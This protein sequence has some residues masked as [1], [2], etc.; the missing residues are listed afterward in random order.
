MTFRAS[1]LGVFV[2]AV[3]VLSACSAGDGSFAVE[4]G[5]DVAQASSAATGAYAVAFYA[6]VLPSGEQTEEDAVGVQ[7]FSDG[8][9]RAFFCGGPSTITSHTAWLSGK[10]SGDTATLQITKEDT[11]TLHFHD[12]NT[13]STVTGQAYR[14]EYLGRPREQLETAA[15]WT[16]KLLRTPNWGYAKTGIYEVGRGSDEHVGLIIGLNVARTEYRKQGAAILPSQVM[17]IEPIGAASRN[18]AGVMVQ[19]G[20]FGGRIDPVVMKQL[21]VATQ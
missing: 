3:A 11:I 2:G 13:N 5:E 18:E 4:E 16:A 20:R 21:T 14:T 15:T 10:R 1:R 12:A 9:V 6:G 17:V 8:S 7:V 19:D